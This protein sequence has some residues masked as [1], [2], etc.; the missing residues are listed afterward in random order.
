MQNIKLFSPLLTNKMKLHAKRE[1]CG[2]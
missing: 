1:Q 2:Y